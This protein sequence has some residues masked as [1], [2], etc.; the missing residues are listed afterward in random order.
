MPS[1]PQR[2]AQGKIVPHDHPEI[3][4]DSFIVRHINPREVHEGCVSSGAY[5]ESKEGGMSVDIETWILT[6]G[7]PQLHYVSAAEGARRIRVGDLRAEGMMVGWDPDGGHPHHG[8]VWHVPTSR[9]GR[10]K[11]HRMTTLL[12]LAEGENPPQDDAGNP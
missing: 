7:L 12:K 4:D 3:T 8:A 9:S 10:R 6:D 1:D 11:I 5:T 2:D